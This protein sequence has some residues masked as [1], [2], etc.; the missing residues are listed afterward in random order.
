MSMMCPQGHEMT[1]NAVEPAD[2]SGLPSTKRRY[3][4]WRCDYSVTTY[5][6]VVLNYTA[7]PGGTDPRRPAAVI[8]A[9]Q[10]AALKDLISHATLI[11]D[12]KDISDL[13]TKTGRRRKMNRI[14]PCTP[15]KRC[16]DKK[17]GTCGTL[18][19]PGTE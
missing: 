4:C 2:V 7:R 19:I 1:V 3:R 9:R 8:T 16:G 18:P 10:L 14:L 12:L 6:V 15:D 5:E 13:P 11:A 17:C